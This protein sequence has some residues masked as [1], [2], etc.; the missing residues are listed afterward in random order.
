M[1]KHLLIATGLAVLSTSAYATKARMDALGQGDFY[2]GSFYVEDSRNVF[3]NAA[4][5]NSM[6]NYVVTEWGTANNASTDSAAA[7][8]AEGGFFRESGSFSYGLYM[9][10]VLNDNNSDR[11]ASDAAYVDHDNALDLFIAGDAGVEWGARIHY[12][13]SKNEPTAST[14]TKH[15]AM[16]VGL[17]I[18]MG[19]LE[20]WT[21]LD[22]SDESEG[23][24]NTNDKWEA[25]LGLNV[26]ASYG[27][28]DMR[29]WVDYAKTGFE[30]TT[31]GAKT[32]DEEDSTITVG[33]GKIHE[34]GSGARLFCDVMYTTNTNESGVGTKTEVTTTALPVTI[35][36]EADATKWLTLR[37]SVRQNVLIGGTETKT[38]STTTKA[39]TANSTNVQ[40]GA[41]LNFGKLKVDG[42]IGLEDS[43]TTELGQVRLDAPMSRVAVHYWF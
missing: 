33:L 6:K 2:R 29:A 21:N 32:E 26:G 23:A 3:R 12:A 27:F 9:G 10:S 37:G 30:V 39:Y 1:K 36:F 34:A 38:G 24:T 13:A 25:A 17:G 31:A 42:M 40:A 14:E 8:A 19:D 22:L 35:G 5:V 18:V 16:G 11:A 41:T 20:V 28:G 43:A 7:P 15:G 4:K